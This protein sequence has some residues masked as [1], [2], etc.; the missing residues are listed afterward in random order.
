MDN[1]Y[2][3]TKNEPINSTTDWENWFEVFVIHKIMTKLSE[4]SEENSGWALKKVPSLEINNNL[5]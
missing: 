4:F 2:L 5:I 1:K 3:S